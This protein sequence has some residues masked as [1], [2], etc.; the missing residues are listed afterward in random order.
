LSVGRFVTLLSPA[1]TAEPIEMPFG[2]W[3]RVGPR[4]HVLGGSR[5]PIWR[6]NFDGENVICTAN[7]WLKEQDRQFFY[8]GIRALEKRQTKYISVAG[9]YDASH[10]GKRAANKGGR[11]VC[12]T[13][14]Q[15]KL[16]TLATVDVFEL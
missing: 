13:C 9:N 5:F 4:N 15:T 14:D 8:S 11:L 3:T 2:V 10:H 12:Q 6:G 7:G 16:I 1:K